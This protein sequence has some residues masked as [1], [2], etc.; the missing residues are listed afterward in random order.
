[1]R[2]VIEIELANWPACPHCE[3]ELPD[4]VGLDG[5]S[6]APVRVT[7]QGCGETFGVQLF[8][9]RCQFGVTP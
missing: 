4:I 2:A 3:A 5:M 1:M 9:D 6:T 8:V 7:C